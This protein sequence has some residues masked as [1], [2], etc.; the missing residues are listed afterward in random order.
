MLFLTVWES[1]RQRKVCASRL[2]S[3]PEYDPSVNT[4]SGVLN[5]GVGDRVRIERNL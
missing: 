2:E 5:S 1:S 3:D 4:S